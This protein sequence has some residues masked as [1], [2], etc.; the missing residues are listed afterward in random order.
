MVNEVYYGGE[1][2]VMRRSKVELRPASREIEQHQ[3]HQSYTY[4][5]PP[6]PPSKILFKNSHSKSYPTAGQRTIRQHPKKDY[7]RLHTTKMG[8]NAQLNLRQN[9]PLIHLQHQK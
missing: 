1:I 2:K 8:Q 3:P 6:P 5:I 9:T 7:Y 4:H